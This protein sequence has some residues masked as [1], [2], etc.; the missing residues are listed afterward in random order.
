M[1]FKLPEEVIR[2]KYTML[3][4]LLGEKQKCLWAASEANIVG[5]GGVSIVQRATGL[6]RQTIHM[7]LK[8]LEKGITAEE[9]DQM[10]RPG[11]GRKST[12]DID[13]QLIVQLQ[14]LA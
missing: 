2:E 7:G 4:H 5:Y 10:R 9:A 13:P 8:E 1:P 12:E 11:G 6:S 14:K 3:Q